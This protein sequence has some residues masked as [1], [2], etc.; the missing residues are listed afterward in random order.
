METFQQVCT[1][2][3]ISLKDEQINKFDRYKEILQAKNK[4]MNLT[5][6][7]SDEDI[8]FKHFF[9]SLLILKYT[10]QANTCC[11]VGSG[12]GF[13]GLVLAIANPNL[14]VTLVEPTAKRVNFLNEVINQLQLKNV[15]TVN[16]RAE[17]F[18][19]E[20]RESFDVVTARAVANLAV[21]SELCLPLVRLGGLFL[22][23]KGAMGETEY[24]G[25]SRA[26]REC[27]G[28]PAILHRDYLP[29]QSVRYNLEIT[30]IAP[31]PLKYPRPYGKIKKDP[32]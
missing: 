22:P 5:A 15:I 21:L 32:L 2:H 18:V 25:A 11:D 29:D 8:M 30:K 28:G 24:D 10:Q 23:M 19:K 13:P 17:D 12:A 20:Y 31:T 14:E 27:G 1:A 9:D 7:T 16:Q 26:I 3:G 6:L 4:V